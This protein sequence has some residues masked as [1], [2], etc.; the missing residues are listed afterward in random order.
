MCAL[1]KIQ[2][3][4]REWFGPGR[5]SGPEA[6]QDLKHAVAPGPQV[7][8]RPGP[9]ALAEEFVGRNSVFVGDSPAEILVG[10]GERQIVAVARNNDLH[11]SLLVARDFGHKTGI[12]AKCRRGTPWDAPPD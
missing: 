3:C 9:R 1:E 6:V 11:G 7:K 4:R 5:T 8:P 12:V 10:R 2:V